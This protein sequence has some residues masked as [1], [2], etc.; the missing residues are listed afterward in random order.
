MVSMSFRLEMDR[1]IIRG[2]HYISPGG[3]AIRFYGKGNTPRDV[4]F[5]FLDYE[6]TIIN[7]RYLDCVVSGLDIY[8]FPNSKELINLLGAGKYEWTEFFVYTGEDSQPD[9]NP[10]R[11]MNIRLYDGTREYALKDYVFPNVMV[12]LT[13]GQFNAVM[14][15]MNKAVRFCTCR[16]MLV[17]GGGI[18]FYES[19]GKIYLCTKIGNGYCYDVDSDRVSTTGFYGSPSSMESVRKIMIDVVESLTSQI[20]FPVKSISIPFGQIK[21]GYC[22]QSVEEVG[23][24]DIVLK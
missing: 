6:G 3:Y 14:N 24:Y 16:Q 12:D 5:D 23:S 9:I 18:R 13:V 17:K 10:V 8:T 21:S 15:I 4:E 2:S 7:D 19:D 22:R 1:P 20:P 11:V